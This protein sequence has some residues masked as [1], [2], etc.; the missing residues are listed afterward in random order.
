MLKDLVESINATSDIHQLSNLA[1]NIK[2]YLSV[3]QDG[4]RLR[5]LTYV[6]CLLAFYIEN[7]HDI[8]DIFKLPI[9]QVFET[10]SRGFIK[11]KS[12][13][14]KI[15]VTE[16]ITL[17]KNLLKIAEFIDINYDHEHFETVF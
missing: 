13:D 2:T 9:I 17:F 7:F 8:A 6:N 15:T 1:A 3:S 10:C 5:D 4:I 12:F 11:E 14:D 16:I